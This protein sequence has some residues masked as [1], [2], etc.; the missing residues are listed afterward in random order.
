MRDT[1]GEGMT[2]VTIGDPERRSLPGIIG[3][4][5]RAA[6]PLDRMK[7]ATA[8]VTRAPRALAAFAQLKGK[9]NKFEPR[10][11]YER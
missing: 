5:Q 6:S 7:Q 2:V 11:V 3:P 10:P 9:F 8:G 4:A 1:E